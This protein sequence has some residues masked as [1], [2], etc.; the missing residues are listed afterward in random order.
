MNAPRKYLLLDRGIVDG[1][2]CSNAALRLCKARKDEAAGRM[3]MEEFFADPPRRWEARYDNGYPVVLRD[4]GSGAFKLYYTTFIKDDDSASTPL[5][6]RR[7]RHYSPSWN[8]ITAVCHASSADGAHWEKPALGFAEFEGSFANNILLKNAHGA[9]VMRDPD[10]PDPSRRYKLIAKMEY[11]REDNWMGV[12]FS[13]D[14]VEFGPPQRW[15]EH[16]PRADT[17]NFAFRD[18]ATGRYVLITRVWKNGMRVA[19]KSESPDFLNWSEPVEIARGMGFG[20]QIYSM[21]VFRHEGIYLGLA[22]IYH[23]G[24]RS[25]P[26]FDT[27][28]LT[29]LYSRDLRRFDWIEPGARL[30]GRGPGRYPDGA[31]DCGCVYASPPV[32]IDGKLCVYYMG[33]N[34]RHTDFRETGLGRAWLEKDK[35]AFYEQKD[36]A[37]DAVIT[38]REANFYGSR[39]RVLADVDDG[40]WIRCELLGAEEAGRGEGGAPAAGAPPAAFVRASGWSGIAFE[41]MAYPLPRS[42]S[43]T[44]RFTFRNARIYALEG[45][46]SIM[47]RD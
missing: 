45:D 28:D 16:N 31:W 12:A 6:A 24:D 46:L 25:D 44:L 10:D 36:G 29:M 32:E 15:P 40:G 41:G 23:E 37:G 2:R 43:R 22:S 34:G 47:G 33:G 13:R 9:S 27:V 39:M 42:A 8:R 35:F 18:P 4:P 11:S 7:E 17:H 20:D 19:A 3:L 26:D 21:P 1:H 38:L 30:I 5:A 14:G